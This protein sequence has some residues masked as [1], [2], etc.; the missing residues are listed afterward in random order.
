[1]IALA[2]QRPTWAVGF[3]DACWWSRVRH[4]A[5]HTWADGEALRCIAQTV[6]THASDPKALAC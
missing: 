5:L 3:E 1:M 6:D 2:E 4:P